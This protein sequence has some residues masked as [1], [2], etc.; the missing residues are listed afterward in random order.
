VRRGKAE[1]FFA[2]DH[3]QL[4]SRASFFAASTVQSFAATGKSLLGW[5][6]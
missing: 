6:G 2:L 4:L 1:I 3:V 5:A